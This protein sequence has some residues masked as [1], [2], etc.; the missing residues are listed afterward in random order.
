[1][2][3]HGPNTYRVMLVRHLTDPLLPYK[4]CRSGRGKQ[5][6]LSIEGRKQEKG[7][8]PRGDMFKRNAAFIF[9]PKS[10]G[11]LIASPGYHA[12]R[13]LHLTCI[14]YI[15]SAERNNTCISLA[16]RKNIWRNTI[17]LEPITN[18]HATLKLA[19]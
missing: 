9:L 6:Y 7:G 14:S 18:G 19:C 11:L 4:G 3:C 10:V 16:S 5:M 17:C 15:S 12:G 1:M 2:G 13:M 8:Q